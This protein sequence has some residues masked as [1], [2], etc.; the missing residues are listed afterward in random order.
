V[1]GILVYAGGAAV[2]TTTCAAAT[3]V[4]QARSGTETA[5]V[6]FDPMSSL[7][8]EFET[9]VG[10]EPTR[11]YDGVTGV[12]ISPEAGQ[13]TYSELFGLLAD[14]V[15]GVGIDLD[16]GHVADLVENQRVPFGRE[17]AALEA[18][19]SFL[20]DP[21]YGTVVFDTGPHGRLLRLLRTPSMVGQGVTAVQDVAT[22]AGRAVADAA[23]R[24][25]DPFP[26]DEAGS[27]DSPTGSGDG[28]GGGEPD[29]GAEI[30]T[31]IDAVR[32]TVGGA[33]RR[34][35]RVVTTPE[36]VAVRY[37]EH[38]V[39]NVANAGIPA[40]PLVVNRVLED[41]DPD[42]ARCTARRRH[43]Q[44]VIEELR[45]ELRELD[46]CVVPDCQGEVDGVAMLER[47]ADRV[48]E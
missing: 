46:V 5:V 44:S 47:L 23:D 6:S 20:Q 24:I 32:S 15:D 30:E 2:G 48:P 36:E 31:R 4:A 37:T 34:E 16:D 18:V 8:A 26:W 41:V 21:R 35:L 11:V 13:E 40:G 22:G 19:A 39:D 27:G 10:P 29:V 42:C 17:V 12:E 1:T 38:L 45:S 33:G 7:S 43:Q 9:D 28:G 3:A 25:P 14:A